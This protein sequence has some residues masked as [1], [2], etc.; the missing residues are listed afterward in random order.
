MTSSFKSEVAATLQSYASRAEA[1]WEGTRDHDVSQNIDALLRHIDV[2]VPWRILDLGCGPGR[3]LKTFRELG[4][5]PVGLDG[6]REFVEMAR[7]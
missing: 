6:V 5:V 7:L 2:P 3:D 1:F 4:H